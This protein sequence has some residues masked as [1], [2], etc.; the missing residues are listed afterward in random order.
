MNTNQQKV[1][2]MKRLLLILAA[3]CIT[4]QASAGLLPK[5]RFGVKAGFDYQSNDI[6]ND[7][8]NLD[9]KSNSGWFAGVQGD[10]SWGNIG[11]RPEVIYSHNKFNVDG[12]EIA[13]KFKLSKLDIPVL[14]QYKL[15]GIVALQAGP[16]FCVMTDT[17]GTTEGMQW[18]IKRPTIGYAAGVE[19]EIWKIGIS[20]RYNGSFKK[21]EVLGYSTGTNRINTIQLGVGFY[22]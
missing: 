1:Q 5:F 7:I 18:N 15:L 9:I 22:F 12:A 14:L 6:K 19:V 13:D 21:S 2:P 8:K 11:V 20:A 16:S 4:S 3:I 17:K 10:L